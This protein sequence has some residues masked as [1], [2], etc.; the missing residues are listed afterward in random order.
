L[1]VTSPTNKFHLDFGFVEF[2]HDNRRLFP[3]CSKIY[4]LFVLN[5]LVDAIRQTVPHNDNSVSKNEFN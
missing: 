2:R 5:L 3:D 4:A 1:I